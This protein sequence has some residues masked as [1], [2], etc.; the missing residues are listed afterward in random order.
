M[1]VE[2]EVKD[3]LRLSKGFLSLAKRRIFIAFMVV[4]KHLY[5]L[6]ITC[7]VCLTCRPQPC[8]TVPWSPNSLTHPTMPPFW[9]QSRAEFLHHKYAPATIPRQEAQTSLKKALPTF[10][11][12]EKW[13]GWHDN[14][15]GY[16]R[17]TKQFKFKWKD[18]LGKEN[19]FQF[20]I[21]VLGENKRPRIYQ[22]LPPWIGNKL[23][24]C[25]AFSLTLS[26]AHHF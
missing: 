7:A 8:Y 12:Y 9:L 23:G 6:E 10:L 1:R 11:L 4:L 15:L 2:G 13:C 5:A 14:I 19:Q 21:Q 18:A 24:G 25:P 3:D 16:A 17:N 22:K 20:S 26:V